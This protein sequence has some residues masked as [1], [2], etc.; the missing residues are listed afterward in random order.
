MILV[1]TS[2]YSYEDWRGIF[3]PPDLPKNRFLE[4]YADRFA[5]VE[6]NYTYYRMPARRTLEA[7]ARKTG[8]RLTFAVKLHGSMTHERTAGPA[9][10]QAFREACAPLAEAGVLG[11]V[12]AQ[13]PYSFHAD[14]ANRDYLRRLREQLPDLDLIAEMRN[15]RWVRQSAFELLKELG[16]GWCNVDEP[17]LPGLMPRTAVATSPTGYVRFHGRNAE[18][19]YQHERAEER[20]NYLYAEQ[21]LAEW[22]SDLESLEKLTRRTFVFT[23]NHFEAKAVK[24][25]LMIVDLLKNRS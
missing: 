9:D 24:N 19:W 12:L 16:I 25:A 18:K 13:F 11:P 14:D 8:G 5:A 17:K 23:N 3:Y 1:G 15:S 6:I 22:R 21:E 2:G 20:Y 7:M 10:Y 4:F